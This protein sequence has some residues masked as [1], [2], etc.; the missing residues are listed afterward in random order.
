MVMAGVLA[1]L[2]IGVPNMSSRSNICRC[3]TYCRVVARMGAGVHPVPDIEPGDPLN[4]SFLLVFL[5][6]LLVLLLSR[7]LI[8]NL[9]A[10]L[11]F[12]ASNTTGST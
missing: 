6:Y 10:S 1:D 12:A 11:L 4:M 2:V 3:D 9:G 7:A 8:Y 5:L